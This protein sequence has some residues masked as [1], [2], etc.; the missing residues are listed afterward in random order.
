[1]N[2]KFIFGF[3][4][5]SALA[6]TAFADSFLVPQPLQNEIFNEAEDWIDDMPEGLQD[7]ISDAVGHSLYGFFSEITYFRNIGEIDSVSYRNVIVKDIK[8][9]NNG[10][11]QIRLYSDRLDF[12]E[13]TPLMIYFHGGGWTIGSLNT[14]DRF[15][16]ALVSLGNVN[17]ASIGYPLAPEI[18]AEVIIKKCSEAIESFT[19]KNKKIILGGDG[20]GGNIALSSFFYLKSKNPDV[21]IK[22]MVLYYPLLTVNP[23]KDSELWRKFGR[24][25]GLDSRVLEMFVKAYLS[26]TPLLDLNEIIVSPLDAG[27]EIIKQLPPV[28][29]ISAGRDLILNDEKRFLE[30]LKE[31]GIKVT[32]VDFEGAIH[33]FIT[34]NH[35]KKA[36][37]KAVELTDLFINN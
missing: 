25:Y 19:T 5:I 1:M 18:S 27:E 35:Q 14:A 24:G 36:F 31:S 37:D 15:C 10:D 22:S 2:K 20:A 30:K 28:L 17:V 32:A 26:Q 29:L 6:F 4:F 8:G 11:L 3:L 7:K 34:D 9:G 16:R 12:D 23:D 21:S 13:E 33:G